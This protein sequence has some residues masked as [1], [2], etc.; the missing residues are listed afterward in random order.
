MHN[1]DANKHMNKLHGQVTAKQGG[2]YP[3][4]KSSGP[5]LPEKLDT[6][7]GSDKGG[8]GTASSSY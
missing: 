8:N 3:S 7:R 1:P 2:T 5:S 6:C 4:N